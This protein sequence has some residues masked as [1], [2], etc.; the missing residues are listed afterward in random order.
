MQVLTVMA[1]AA[2]HGIANGE[3]QTIDNCCILIGTTI[4]EGSD[5]WTGTTKVNPNG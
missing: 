4:K 5:L 2:L 1:Q 3:D